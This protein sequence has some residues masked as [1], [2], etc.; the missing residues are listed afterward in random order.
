MARTKALLMIEEGLTDI[1]KASPLGNDPD[2]VVQRESDAGAALIGDLTDAV[3]E[4]V[5]RY[6]E[7]LGID[8]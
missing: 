8:D 2:A 4:I 3:L 6:D 7:A 5:G 1:E